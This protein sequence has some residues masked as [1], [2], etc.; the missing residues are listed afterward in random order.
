MP[1][2]T[3]DPM[4]ATSPNYEEDEWA[5]IRQSLIGAHIGDEPLTNEGAVEK[6][7]EAW[8]QLNDWKI[9][10]WN[11]QI[12]ND[13]IAEE[14][15]TQEAREEERRRQMEAEREAEAERK[16]LEK[17]KPKLN[18]FNPTKQVDSHI[19]PRPAAY[20]LN[21]IQQLEYVEL[22]YF[23]LRGCQ[24]AQAE[25]R[26]ATLQ[27]TFTFAKGDNDIVALRPSLSL[28][29][30][31]NIKMDNKLDWLEIGI[32]KNMMLHHMKTSGVW[33]EKHLMSLATF[34]V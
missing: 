9:V 18:N 4:K 26:K 22:D 24:E 2:I 28:K 30:L 6:L 15:A 14:I 17:K 29:A 12:C 19:A 33:P 10:E 3:E 7:K 21:K 31:K 13:E 25:H 5:F 34:Y 20:T 11:E 8:I 23:T 16:E 1:R 27:D 32:A